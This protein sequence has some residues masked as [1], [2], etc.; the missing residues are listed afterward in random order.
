MQGHVRKRTHTTKD[1][2]QSVTWYVVVDIGRD[3]NNRRRQKW[4]GGFRTRKEAEVARAKIV[5]DLHD[6]TYTEPSRLTLAEWVKATWLPT[7][8][9][10]VKPSTF[11]S[12]RRN[13]DHHVLPHL[14]SRRLR[15]VTP[16]QLNSLYG[17]LL[18]SGRRNG[19][20]GGLSPKTVRYIHTI[21]HKALADAADD[22]LIATNVAER[23]KP[24]RPRA[25]NPT[26]IRFWQPDELR[27]FFEV[28]A[29]HR[30]EGAWHLAAMT[31]MRRGEVLGLRWRDLD[32]DRSRLHVRQ[33]LVSVAYEVLVSSPKSH[34]ARVIDL[35][36]GTV[37]QL[38]LHRKRQDAERSEWEADY[39]DQDLVVCKEN[40]TPLHPQTFSQAF[41]RIVDK[42]D[43]PRIRLHDLRHTH[44]TVALRAGVPV[45]V[46]SERLGHENPAFTMKQYAHVM[47][48][49]QAEAA[50]LV[51]R[52]VGPG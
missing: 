33:A 6:G 44:A 48:G 41:E 3:E 2:R 38:R 18:E 17:E 15:D 31:G 29:G 47:P 40:G 27:A 42:T 14:G 51:A 1:G 45:K 21:V 12:Y 5:A 20:G 37:E 24:P 11:E 34:R 50:K 7:V 26:E 22:G 43:L 30:L 10:Q 39:E 23:A 13:M 19:D 9:T 46:I 16:S 36:P 28:I 32:L 52:L 4:H 25:T 8:K 35:D 49:M